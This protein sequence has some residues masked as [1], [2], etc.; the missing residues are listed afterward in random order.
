MGMFSIGIC[1]NFAALLFCLKSLFLFHICLVYPFLAFSLQKFPIEFRYFKCFP[2]FS[3][4]WCI[5]YKLCIPIC[6]QTEIMSKEKKWNEKQH[7]CPVFKMERRYAL[8]FL[9]ICIEQFNFFLKDLEWGVQ[10]NSQVCRWNQII[11]DGGLWR[12]SKGSLQTSLI[13]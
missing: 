12:L 10:L 11:Q 6:V 8:K 1:P 3:D 13:T 2:P 7:K 9:V 4:R 5:M